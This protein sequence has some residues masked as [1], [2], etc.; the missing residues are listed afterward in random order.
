MTT[1]FNITWG[2]QQNSLRSTIASLKENKDLCDITLVGEDASTFGAHKIILSSAS[3]FFQSLVINTE[4]YNNS[5]SV[6]FMTGFKENQL[7]YLMSFIYEGEAI[8]SHDSLEEFLDLTRSLNLQGLIAGNLINYNE[9]SYENDKK[10]SSPQDQAIF[11]KTES[12]EGYFYQGTEDDKNLVTA[13]EALCL[14]NMSESGKITNDLRYKSEDNTI[15]GGENILSSVENKIYCPPTVIPARQSNKNFPCGK[16]GKFFRDSHNLKDH[17]KYKHS[18]NKRKCCRTFCSKLFDTRE[19]QKNHMNSC[20][21]QC[22]VQEC[23]KQFT[24][25][26]H[27]ER[28]KRF[29]MN[30]P[31]GYFQR[32]TNNQESL[33]VI[34]DNGVKIIEIKNKITVRDTVK[35]AEKLKGIWDTISNI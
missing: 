24:R 32:K 23:R 7:R 9:I 12:N 33:N 25:E 20:F 8:I 15:S 4:Q 29:H 1:N 18:I 35:I 19:D 6:I 10:Y 2:D 28:H 13:R 31:R 27:F 26:K 17:V 16:C 22:T 3:I 14:K 5:N 11:F 21:L 30:Y 34:K